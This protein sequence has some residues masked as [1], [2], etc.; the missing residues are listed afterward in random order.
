MLFP[1]NAIQQ[2]TTAPTNPSAS[3][4]NPAGL[5]DQWREWLRKPQNSSMLLQSGIAMLQPM[6]LGQTTMGAIGNAVGSGMEAHDAVIQ[7]QRDA[8]QLATQNEQKSAEIANQQQVAQTGA[9]R[10][11]AETPYWASM[12]MGSLLRG[13]AAYKKA[14]DPAAVTKNGENWLKFSTRA[15]NVDRANAALRRPDEPVIGSPEY[16]SN[17]QD[18]WANILAADTAGQP[19]NVSTAAPTTPQTPAAADPSSPSIIYSPEGKPFTVRN[20]QWVPM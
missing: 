2:T 17:L 9:D 14:F 1:T 6:G 11:K 20:G 19:G 8:A 13:Q 3:A 18:V 4:P 16:V 12:G 5:A 7:K 10:V 15:M